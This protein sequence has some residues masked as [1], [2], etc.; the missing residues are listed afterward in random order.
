MFGEG[1]TSFDQDAEFL[2]FVTL[3]EQTRTSR[4]FVLPRHVSETLYRAL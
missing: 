2:C 1:Y 4:S 3:S